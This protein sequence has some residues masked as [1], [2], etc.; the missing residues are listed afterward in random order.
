MKR[1]VKARVMKGARNAL[2]VTMSPSFESTHSKSFVLITVSAFGERQAGG[3]SS[4]QGGRAPEGLTL[5][6][7]LCQR[8][9]F[10][11]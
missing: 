3:F 10:R 9:E 4:A 7:R 6:C 11:H 2:Q 1:Y 8:L 5:T